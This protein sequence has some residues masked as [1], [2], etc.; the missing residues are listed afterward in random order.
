MSSQS[1]EGV[2]WYIKRLSGNDT[3][4]NGSHQAGPYIPKSFLFNVFPELEHIRDQNAKKWFDVLID[5]HAAPPARVCATWYNNKLRDGTRDEARVTNFGGASSPLLDESNTGALTVFSFAVGQEDQNVECRVWVCSSPDEEDVVEEK[6]GEVEPA[7]TRIW[8][9]DD[10]LRV[11]FSVGQGKP[12]CWLTPAQLPSAWLE[13]FPS[14]AEIIQKAIELKPLSGKRPDVRLLSRRDCEFELFRSV[15]EAI[16]LPSI[17]AGFNTIDGF[18]ARAQSILQRRKARAGRSLELHAKKIFDEEDLIE[19]LDYDHQPVSEG[20]KKPDFLFPSESAYK[21]DA[22]SSSSLRM[23]AVKTTCKD[24]WR[25]IL[26]EADRIPVKHLLTLQEGV[27]VNQFKEMQGAGVRLV[28]PRA[29]HEKYP[30]EIRPELI[31]VGDFLGDVRG[32]RMAAL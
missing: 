13:R 2:V 16:E 31:S 19:G 22:F 12:K 17:L 6:V 24:R 28:V 15:E 3:L 7:Q 32:L 5:S 10:R 20:N 18:V 11:M 30:K 8:T 27:S 1:G 23:L 21:N 25:Q 26:N 4:A 9:I 29:L 14:G